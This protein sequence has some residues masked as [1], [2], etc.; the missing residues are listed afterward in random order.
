MQVISKCDLNKGGQGSMW[1][2]GK[3]FQTKHPQTQIMCQRSQKDNHIPLREYGDTPHGLR[4]PVLNQEVQSEAAMHTL[5][6][7]LHCTVG[8]GDTSVVR[9]LCPMATEVCPDRQ[10]FLP[11]S[12]LSLAHVLTPSL[13]PH[14]WADFHY[15]F[16]PTA[17]STHSS[18][19]KGTQP[20]S[21][22]RLSSKLGGRR[23][24]HER[25]AVLHQT[26]TTAFLRAPHRNRYLQVKWNQA[27]SVTLGQ[28]SP[29]ERASY[30]TSCPCSSSFH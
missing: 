7:V 28:A 16:I 9:L 27:S 17:A 11:V 6:P 3:I 5:F 15:P 25:D 13:T 19:T 14:R 22:K 8:A 30:D 18:S 12:I 26:L 10:I 1:I 29:Q 24:R 20:S 4:N 23:S 21:G 2:F